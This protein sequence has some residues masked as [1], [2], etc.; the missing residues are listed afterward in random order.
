[1]EFYLYDKDKLIRGIQELCNVNA[2]WGI[3]GSLQIDV[4]KVYGPALLVSQ[5]GVKFP[6]KKVM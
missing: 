4:T 6:E 5:G 1:M 3:Y 2:V